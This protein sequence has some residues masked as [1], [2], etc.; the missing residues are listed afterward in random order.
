MPQP[1]ISDVHIDFALT[2]VSVAYMQDDAD[3]VANQVFPRVPVPNQTN[4]YWKYN[5]GDF[6]RNNMQKRADGTPAASGGWKMATGTYSCDVWAEKKIIG[7]QTRANADPSFNLDRDATVWLTQ[8]A[9]INREVQWGTNYFGTSIWGTDITGVGSSPSGS[10]TL[11]WDK[12][13]SD[14][15]SDYLAGQIAIKQATGMWPNTSV[16]GAQVYIKLLTNAS[17]IDRLK[18]G[19]TAPGPVIVSQ[20]DLAALFKLKRFLVMGGVQTTSAED[21]TATDSDTNPDTLAF[22]GG[23]SALLAYTPDAPGPLTP[24]AGYTFE[25]TGAGGI[26]GVKIKKFRWEVDAADHMEI[27]QAYSFGVVSKWLGYFF[28]TI[29]S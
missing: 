3:F 29:V 10:Q 24:A 6:F 22:I 7:D 4:K 1:T 12:S 20:N 18:Y 8:Q 9:L 21:L 26:S 13:G 28:T 14:P 17:I 23:K 2:N 5:R 15:V 16:V 27:E 19:Q 11:Q 25:W